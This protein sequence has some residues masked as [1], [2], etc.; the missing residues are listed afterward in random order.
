[1]ENKGKLLLKRI[2]FEKSDQKDTLVNPENLRMQ[3][4]LNYKPENLS[5]LAAKFQ[6]SNAT[7]KAWLKTIDYNIVIEHKKIFTPKELRIIYEHLG[8]VN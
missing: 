7:F 5:S 1:M 3:E 4:H 2:D 6:V 8:E